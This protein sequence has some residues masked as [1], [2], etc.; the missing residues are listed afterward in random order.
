MAEVNSAEVTAILKK[1][2]SGF[3]SETSLDEVGTVL[4]VDDFG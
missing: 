1:Q 2:I 3:E 4:R